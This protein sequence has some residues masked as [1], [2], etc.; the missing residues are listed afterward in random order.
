MYPHRPQCQNLLQISNIADNCTYENGLFITT[1]ADFDAFNVSNCVTVYGDIYFESNETSF[2]LPSAIKTIN[3]S[4]M[5]DN[6]PDLRTISAPTLIAINGS[7]T[8][9]GTASLAVVSF[10]SLKF[11]RGIE[12]SEL[13]SINVSSWELAVL[14][15]A[16][17]GTCMVTDTNL[18][19]VDGLFSLIGSISTLVIRNPS[20]HLF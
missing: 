12:L 17:D 20:F 2:M 9:G 1:Q 5:L 7:L 13:D 14:I 19:S 3:G 16:S 11:V 15:N 18:T 10:P 4:L 6:A 8:I